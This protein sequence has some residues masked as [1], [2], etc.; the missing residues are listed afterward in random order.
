MYRVKLEDDEIVV[1][2]PTNDWFVSY[3]RT[4]GIK[5]LRVTDVVIDRKTG[6]SERAR[7]LGEG[8]Q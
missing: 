5:G 4:L 2:N 7:F 3:L 8:I 1:T 6:V